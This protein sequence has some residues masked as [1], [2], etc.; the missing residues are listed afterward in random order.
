MVRQ[1]AQDPR[2]RCSCI[3][4]CGA[5]YEFNLIATRTEPQFTE[6]FF[7]DLRTNDQ[8]WRRMQWDDITAHY[9]KISLRMELQ[10]PISN[11]VITPATDT[12][13]ET[14]TDAEYS[15]SMLK[16]TRHRNAHCLTRGILPYVKGIVRRVC[17]SLLQLIS[18]GKKIARTRAP[19]LIRLS[20]LGI[21]FDQTRWNDLLNHPGQCSVLLPRLQVWSTFRLNL[22][23]KKPLTRD[24]Y[25][26]QQCKLQ[27]KRIL[28]QQ[29]KM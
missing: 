6:E 12:N 25:R 14:H 4:D 18:A 8:D 28:L 7:K 26:A 29:S 17:V 2:S 13:K 3:L 9:D 16:A 1:N 15:S 20:S 23:Y 27:R 10:A 5:A 22:N 19:L 21:H 11:P 24:A